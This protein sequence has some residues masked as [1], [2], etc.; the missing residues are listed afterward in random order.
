LETHH[1]LSNKKSHGKDG[2]VSVSRGTYRE[3]GIANDF[4]TAMNQIGYPEVED[5]QDLETANG[6]A[7]AYRYISPDTGRRQNAAD[8][9][10]HPRLEDSKHP[11]LHV[12]VESQVLRVI[13]DENK[14]ATG[15][16]FRPNPKTQVEGAGNVVSTIKVRKL[17]VLSAGTHATPSILERSGI[18]S[19]EI[20]QKANIPIIYDLP[21]VGSNYEDHQM[22]TYTYKASLQPEQTLESVIDGTRNVGELLETNDPILSWN[23]IDANAKL[24]PTD[25]DI[26]ELG[27]EFRKLWDRDYKNVPNKPLA[28]LF[29][30]TGYVLCLFCPRDCSFGVRTD[31]LTVKFIRILADPTP[32]LPGQFFSFACYNAYPYSKGHIVS[33]PSYHS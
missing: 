30:V 31:F 24:R 21:G 14:K 5:L 17:V 7:H 29:L 11:N 25:S 23:G 9:Y 28:A 32:F 12:L 13:L 33:L 10:L 20:L 2:P 16:V 15:V 26:D 19:R 18:G 4:I 6:V 3:G 1:G 27:P 8:T 22:V